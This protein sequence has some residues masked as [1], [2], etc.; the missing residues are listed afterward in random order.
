MRLKR[1]HSDPKP[2]PKRCVP[3]RSGPAL[4]S[5]LS[6]EWSASDGATKP[7]SDEGKARSRSGGRAERARGESVME[8]D[9]GGTSLLPAGGGPASGLGGGLAGPD[10][11]GRTSPSTLTWGVA[12]FC[13]FWRNSAQRFLRIS[14]GKWQKKILDLVQT[15]N[16][17]RAARQIG[18]VRIQVAVYAEFG[19]VGHE[20]GV[21]GLSVA[22]RG[23]R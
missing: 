15:R 17:P 13:T 11:G 5:G 3:D 8:A 12:R 20:D 4:R 16:T 23:D 19:I 14:I 10:R 18:V 21:P 6:A 9:I 1:A 7:R 22:S 2:C